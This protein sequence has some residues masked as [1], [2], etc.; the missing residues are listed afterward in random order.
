[1]AQ[2]LQQFIN[3]HIAYLWLETFE[4]ISEKLFIV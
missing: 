4:Q 1:M 2:P 3:P